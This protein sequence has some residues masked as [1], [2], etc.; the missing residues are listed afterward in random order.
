VIYEMEKITTIKSKKRKSQVQKEIAFKGIYENG[1]IKLSGKKLPKKKM[2]VIV[3]FQEEENTKVQVQER[4]VDDFLKK[5]R[6]VIKSSEI[7]LVM[8]KKFDYLVKKHN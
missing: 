3:T 2:N 4:K 5:W 7:Q 6:G 1:I 8:E